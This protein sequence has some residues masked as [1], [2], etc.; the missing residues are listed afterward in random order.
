MRRS[1]RGC[2]LLVVLTLVAAAAAAQ[3]EPDL[4]P[5]WERHDATSVERV[6]HS[7]WSEFLERYLV[8]DAP[9]GVHLVVYGEV[10]AEDRA[11]LDRYIGSLAATTVTQ[12]SRPEQMAYW[13]N[14]YNAL[15]VQVIL[16]HYPVDS[17]R[18]INLS[19]ALFARGPWQAKLVIIE[20]EEVSL[21]D[22]E[23]RILRPIWRDPRI[24]YAVNCASIGCPDLQPEAFTASRLE[25]M[26]NAA[27][28]AYVNHPRGVSLAGN[29]LTLSSIYD[30]FDEDF[31]GNEE[32]V[33]EHLTRYAEPGLARALRSFSGRI[34]YDYDWSLNEPGRR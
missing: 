12:L 28:A 32:G 27:A 29:R 23:H 14:L 4:W 11:L 25:E 20:G 1:V 5:R 15:T 24:H 21:D 17:I 16:D 18:E 33:I 9:D 34:R 13:I 8:T 31:G 2:I 7:A 22:I 10:T 3:P 6:D 19:R 26:L 30:W